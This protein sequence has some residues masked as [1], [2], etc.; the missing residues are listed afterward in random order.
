MN[1]TITKEKLVKL[2]NE[3]LTRTDKTEIKKMIDD[4]KEGR[5]LYANK[6]RQEE[7]EAAKAKNPPAEAK[8][9]PTAPV[10]VPRSANNFP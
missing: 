5:K 2:I 9:N 7:E 10:F 6:K 8:L 3:E 1:M 4:A